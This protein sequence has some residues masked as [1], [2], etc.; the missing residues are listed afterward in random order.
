M[1][2][3]LQNIIY[4]KI[5]VHIYRYNIFKNMYYMN[6]MNYKILQVY[7]AIKLSYKTKLKLKNIFV[8]SKYTNIYS[9]K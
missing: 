5:S 4:Y 2:L 6:K 7:F 9:L 1:D 3:K 8:E